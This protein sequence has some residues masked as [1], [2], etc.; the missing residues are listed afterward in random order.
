M[1]NGISPAKNNYTLLAADMA[2][3][4]NRIDTLESEAKR[5]KER[6]DGPFPGHNRSHKNNTESVMLK[7]SLSKRMLISCGIGNFDR[8]KAKAYF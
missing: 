4:M 1:D 6:D 2:E 7:H 5:K 8:I 3:V